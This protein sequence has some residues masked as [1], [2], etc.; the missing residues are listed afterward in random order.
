[1]T[2]FVHP[3][4]LVTAPLRVFNLIRTA[5]LAPT[6]AALAVTLQLVSFVAVLIFFRLFGSRNLK[7]TYFV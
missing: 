3:P 7:G 6:T 4:G 5:G 1:V 2:L